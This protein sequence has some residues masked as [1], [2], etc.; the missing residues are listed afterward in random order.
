[1]RTGIRRAIVFALAGATMV[2]TVA[3][4]TMLAHASPTSGPAG[5]ITS[6]TTAGGKIDMFVRGTNKDIFHKE[7]TG[8]SWWPSVTGWEDLG[9]LG[10]DSNGFASAPVA[11]S[12]GG[13][14]L[15]VFVVDGQGFLNHKWWNGSSWGPSTFEW[16]NLGTPGVGSVLVGTPTVTAHGSGLDLFA[17]DQSGSVFHKWWNGSSWGPSLRGFEYMGASSSS[18]AVTDRSGLLDL[19]GYD[20]NGALQHKW[21]NGSSWNP[22]VTGWEN[23]GGDAFTGSPSATL[24]GSVIDVF[25]RDGNGV[26]QHKW[27]NGSRWNGWES[28][29]GGIAGSPV[30]VSSG[31]GTLDIFAMGDDGTLQHKWWNGSSWGGWE[32][33]GGV[34][35][36]DPSVASRG[37]QPLDVFVRGTDNAVYHKWWNGSWGPSRFTF[38]YMGGVILD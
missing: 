8:S 18:I 9:G 17:R 38:E 19:F 26:M 2:G 13:S 35:S 34:I 20:R 28:L 11:V 30:A 12:S 36:G 33:L 5:P 22:A 25:A 14:T 6:V 27:W 29:G 15:D 4:G 7:W 21:W 37:T 10:S 1:M 3:A 23:L 16:E 31:N 24:S 32:S